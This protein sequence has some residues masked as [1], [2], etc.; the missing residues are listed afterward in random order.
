[1]KSRTKHPNLLEEVRNAVSMRKVFLTSHAIDRIS[2]RLIPHE[3]SV[4]DVFYVL[5]TGFHESR[6]DIWDTTH[7][8]WNYAIRGKTLDGISLRVPVAIEVD[9]SGVVVITVINLDVEG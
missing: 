2:E 3:M 4:E 8:V 6:K 5:K 9:S 1:M 7:S